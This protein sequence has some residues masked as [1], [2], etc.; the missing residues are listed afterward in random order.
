MQS[1]RKQLPAN[2]RRSPAPASLAAIGDAFVGE[3]RAA[4]LMAPSALAPDESNWLINPRHA[5]F[6]KIRVDPVEKF[7]CDARFF[8]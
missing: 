1:P 7:R 5:D 8:K 6:S 2:W 4:I 3:S